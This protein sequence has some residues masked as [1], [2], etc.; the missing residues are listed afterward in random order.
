[1][2]ASLQSVAV[3]DFFFFPQPHSESSVLVAALNLDLV[4]LASLF[5]ELMKSCQ[6]EKL[7]TYTC[8]LL[9]ESFIFQCTFNKNTKLQK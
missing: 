3:V 9:A 5:M 6:K 1:M 7:S 4:F 8:V 2:V